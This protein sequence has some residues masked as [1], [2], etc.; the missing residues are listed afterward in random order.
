MNTRL[1]GISIVLPTLLIGLGQILASVK[2]KMPE[3][4]QLVRQANRISQV[5]L[6]TQQ[7][8]PLYLATKDDQQQ[9]CQWLGICDG[10][11]KKKK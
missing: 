8:P 9:E 10:K 3:N 7:P 6:S 2:L 11:D 4:L 1:L 5:R